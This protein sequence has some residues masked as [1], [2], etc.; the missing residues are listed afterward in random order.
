MKAKQNQEE[1]ITRKEMNAETHNGIEKNDYS[2]THTQSKQ[3]NEQ[4]KDGETN[5]KLESFFFVFAR[6]TYATR[7]PR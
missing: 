6:Y 4:R 5:R 2:Q 1:Q 3:I 7:L